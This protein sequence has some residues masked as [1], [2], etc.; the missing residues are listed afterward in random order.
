VIDPDPVI[1]NHDHELRRHDPQVEAQL[2]FPVWVGVA[3]GGIHIWIA[4][5]DMAIAMSW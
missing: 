2:P 4:A 5:V 3:K 1:H